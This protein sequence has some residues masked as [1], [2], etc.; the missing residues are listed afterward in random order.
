M[1]RYFA[2]VGRFDVVK[3]K[4]GGGW[5]GAYLFSRGGLLARLLPVCEGI[6]PYGVLAGRYIQARFSVNI[7]LLIAGLLA[8]GH[9][10]P[11]FMVHL[12]SRNPRQRGALRPPTSVEAAPVEGSQYRP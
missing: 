9:N 7:H 8:Q 4:L 11:R 1:T 10:I 6:V 3:L 12:Q 2:I 5:R